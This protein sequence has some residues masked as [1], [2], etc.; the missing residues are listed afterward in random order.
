M[1]I[2]DL[3]NDIDNTVRPLPDP[4]SVQS[5]KCIVTSDWHVPFISNELF[6]TLMKKG[7]SKRI[8]TLIVAGDFM[9]CQELS[10]FNPLYKVDFSDEKRIAKNIIETISKQFKHIYF[11]KGNH[12]YRYI[13]QMF[14]ADGIIGLFDSLGC[15]VEINVSNLDYL[16][17]NDTWRVSHPSNYSTIPLRVAQKLAA[18]Y[19]S[20]Q[21]VG[22]QHDIGWCYDDSGEFICIGSAGLFDPNRLEYLQST[23]TKRRQRNGFVIMENYDEFEIIRGE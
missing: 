3:L 16:Y 2:N 19:K 12:E 5:K 18:K 21:I 4:F 17:L 7:K 1:K 9:D 13:K 8:N 23:N 6:I 10:C 14:G 15:N 22:H 11:L 20:N